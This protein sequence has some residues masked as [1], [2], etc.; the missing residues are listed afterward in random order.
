MYTE[1]CSVS[2]IIVRQPGYDSYYSFNSDASRVG[3]GNRILCHAAVGPRTYSPR[4]NEAGGDKW[5][6]VKL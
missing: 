1:D 6:L 2:D 3:G 4:Q 5:Q